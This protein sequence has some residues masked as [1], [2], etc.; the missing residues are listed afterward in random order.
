MC[1]YVCVV[2]VRACVR[3]Y[4]YVCYMCICIHVCMCVCVCVRSIRTLGYTLVCINREYTS[5]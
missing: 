2:C 3:V 5:T 1:V 4:V